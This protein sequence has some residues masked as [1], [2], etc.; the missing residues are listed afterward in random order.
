M[1]HK[2]GREHYLKTIYLLSKKGEVHGVTIAA[3]MGITRPTVCVAMK[4]LRE[5]GYVTMESDYSIH[6]TELGKKIAV[7]THD[8]HMTFKE[9]LISLGVDEDI[10]IR[11]ACE[12]EH[13]VGPESFLALKSLLE[14]R[15]EGAVAEG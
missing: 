14:P 8:R 12:L 13:S 4:M 3:E 5:E 1:K 15:R 11:D 9:L 10:A 7:E 2:R 6:L